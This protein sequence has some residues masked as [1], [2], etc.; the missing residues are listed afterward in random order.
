MRI[1]T[2]GHDTARA[3]ATGRGRPRAPSVVTVGSP[4]AA[5]ETYGA[6][7]DALGLLLTIVDS[8]S[9]KARREMHRR[10]S[11]RAI[12]DHLHRDPERQSLGGA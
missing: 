9:I 5:P 3:S 11:S 7:R 8:S 10:R 2:C 4:A 6:R 12:Q 1:R